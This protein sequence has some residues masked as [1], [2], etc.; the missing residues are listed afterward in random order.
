MNTLNRAVFFKDVQKI[1]RRSS[2]LYVQIYPESSFSNFL[3]NTVLRLLNAKISLRVF[4]LLYTYSENTGKVFK[5]MWRI[6]QIRLLELHKIVSEYA[7]RMYA[8][9]EKTPRDTKLSI[10]QLIIQI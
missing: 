9:I 5:R 6:R 10:S 8:Y 4:L 3:S 1:K 2:S 7:E